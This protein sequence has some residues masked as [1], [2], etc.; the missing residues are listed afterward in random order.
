MHYHGSRELSIVDNYIYASNTRKRRYFY[1]YMAIIIK[2]K[3]SQHNFVP[4]LYCQHCGD[5][6]TKHSIF[7]S[8]IFQPTPVLTRVTINDRS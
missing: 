1:V 7:R 5:E 6:T 8:F 4:T 3:A 2:E